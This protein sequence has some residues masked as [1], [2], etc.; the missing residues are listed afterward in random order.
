MLRRL[1]FDNLPSG[2]LLNIRGRVI[3]KLTD[4]TKTL[5]GDAKTQSEREYTPA[6]PSSH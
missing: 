3:G 4:V 1:H 2:G 5:L 6:A